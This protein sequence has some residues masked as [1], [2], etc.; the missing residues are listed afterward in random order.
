M[1]EEH[2]KKTKSLKEVNYDADV[3]EKLSANPV[4]RDNIVAIIEDF[5][6]LYDK[7]LDQEHALNDQQ[8]SQVK[9]D[10]FAAWCYGLVSGMDAE[11]NFRVRFKTPVELMPKESPIITGPKDV[12]KPSGG[13][14]LPKT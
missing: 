3:L 11:S 8:L 12:K 7:V 13:L 2:E 4:I 10:W 5:E 6:F 9:S 1:A 14:I